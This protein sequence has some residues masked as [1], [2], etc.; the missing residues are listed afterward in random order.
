MD[1]KT[2]F[3]TGAAGYVG[4]MLCAEFAS[5]DDV[6][7]IIALDKES[8]PEILNQYKN[9]IWINANT[10]DLDWQ[11]EVSLH[12]PNIV[13]HTAWQIREMF[14]QKKKQWHWNIGGSDNV[15]DFAFSRP[16]VH[17]L[18][19]FSTIASYAAYP[20]NTIEHRFTEDEP[21]RVSDYLYAE[22][23][24]IA[25][26]HLKD[27]FDA[28]FNQDETT[29]P[30]VFIIRPASITGPR[31]RYSKIRL[32]LQSVLSG[33]LKDNFLHKVISAMVSFVPVT[34]KWCRQFIHEDDIV[35]IVTAISFKDVSGKFEIFNACPP[36]A[37]VQGFDMVKAVGKKAITIPPIL[38]RFVFFLAWNLSRGRIPTSKGGWKS[39]SY[40]I[41]VD[42]SKIT[43]TL[44]YT[45]KFDP[46]EA[47]TKKEGRYMKFVKEV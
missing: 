8:K 40:P 28:C 17:K 18:I 27:K 39:Y 33:Q 16:S 7:E 12:N 44:G 45:Y 9:I 46:K 25:E 42:G 19:H 35:D 15:F 38:I 30:Q 36:G 26:Q 41:A 31:G 23:K 2:I 3:I 21:F 6:K 34:K 43:R 13:I 37:V 4:T 1:T 20:S 47:F 5:H 11:K 24:R 29:V 22:E 14:G 10:A 32:G